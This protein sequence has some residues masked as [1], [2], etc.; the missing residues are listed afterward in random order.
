[1]SEQK[2]PN[3]HQFKKRTAL[4]ILK[5]D[6]GTI[7]EKGYEICENVKYAMRIKANSVIEAW[8]KYQRYYGMY[9]K[10]INE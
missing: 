7:L 1:M 9:D 5:A 6:N 2:I 4:Y 8:K 3:L 10:A